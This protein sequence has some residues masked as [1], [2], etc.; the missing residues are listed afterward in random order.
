VITW[1]CARKPETVR[2]GLHAAISQRTER[3]GTRWAAER[4]TTYT[5]PGDKAIGSAE[6][7]FGGGR[8]GKARYD[9]IDDMARMWAEHFGHHDSSSRDAVVQY[10]G[11]T[12]G[13]HGH[14]YFRT[15]PAVASDLVLTVRYG[16]SP[17][18][19]NGRPLEHVEG[20]FWKIDDDYLQ[21]LNDK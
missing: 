19:E 21:S 1:F 8:F 17:G 6:W 10:E 2:F 15:N 9:N 4:W 12:G 16:R 5:S 18:A 3:E 13:R 14:D 20:L 7:L 11:R